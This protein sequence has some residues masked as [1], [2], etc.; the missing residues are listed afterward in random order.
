MITLFSKY[1]TSLIWTS[2][3]ITTTLHSSLFKPTISSW[4]TSGTSCT[5]CIQSHG[6]ILNRNF[7]LLIALSPA[8]THFWWL[9][10]ISFLILLYSSC[11]WGILWL[12]FR[13]VHELHW[14]LRRILRDYTFLSEYDSKNMFT[15]I[16]ILNLLLKITC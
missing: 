8:I 4:I 16:E 12:W 9:L 10:K 3:A 2:A 14:F 1:C 15:K 5:S 7:R 13:L 6:W 11:Y